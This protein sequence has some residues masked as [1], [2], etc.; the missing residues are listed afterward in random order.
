M[1]EI[2]KQHKQFAESQSD[3]KN[4]LTRRMALFSFWSFLVF[5]LVT[6]GFMFVLQNYHGPVA[7]WLANVIPIFGALGIISGFSIGWVALIKNRKAPSKSIFIRSLVGISVNGLL[8]LFFSVLVFFSIKDYREQSLKETPAE[9]AKRLYYQSTINS[10]NREARL[11]DFTSRQ[12]G[13]TNIA[14]EAASKILQKQRVLT[15]SLYLA[16]EPLNELG[17]LLEMSN[18]E[19]SEDLKLREEL[20]QKFLEANE[21]FGLFVTSA[22]SEY[23]SELVARGVS[24]P[25]ADYFIKKFHEGWEKGLAEYQFASGIWKA[26]DQWARSEITA[27]GFLQTNWGHWSYDASLKK[28]K[29]AND[30]LIKEY[31]SLVRE[32]NR[33]D[34]ERQQIRQQI[35]S[36]QNQ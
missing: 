20:L 9:R 1:N 32:I 14:M 23:R 3:G 21:Q 35:L 28:T 2:E 8:I 31:N 25:T 22:E 4:L 11:H 12:V 5:P 34:Q 36:K 27:L 13:D 24:Q 18:V 26:N 33:F 15:K 19:K 16:S 6:F 30:P 29:F 17:H 7:R 10:R